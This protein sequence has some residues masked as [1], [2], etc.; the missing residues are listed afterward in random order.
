MSFG[1]KTEEIFNLTNLVDAIVTTQIGYYSL[2][3]GFYS[4]NPEYTYKKRYINYYTVGKINKRLLLAQIFH[5]KNMVKY[6]GDDLD[7]K[8]GIL[9]G[10][11]AYRAYLLFALG[12]NDVDNI[13]FIIEPDD[14][15]DKIGREYYHIKEF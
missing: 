7:F 13:G 8:F 12:L 4:L 15:K 10:N 6:F 3:D 2:S 14:I 9:N 1:V 11:C 5:I